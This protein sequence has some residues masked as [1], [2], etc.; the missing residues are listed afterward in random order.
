MELKKLRHSET[1][2]YQLG[3]S[4]LGIILLTGLIGIRAE[5]DTASPTVAHSPFITIGEIKKRFPTDS[6]CALSY[7]KKRIFWGDGDQETWMNLDGKDVKLLRVQMSPKVKI[8]QYKNK[9][10]LITI[11]AGPPVAVPPPG[12][13]GMEGEIFKN[14]KITFLK[15][16]RSFKI[17]V[18]GGCDGGMYYGL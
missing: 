10:M 5:A 3:L 17:N 9:D 4:F 8:A 18:V 13:I 11:D 2:I 1:S 15:G 12:S 7:Q 6:A 16:K 14:V